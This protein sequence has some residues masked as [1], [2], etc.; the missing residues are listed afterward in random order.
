[1]GIIY[2]ASPVVAAAA[3]FTF[4]MARGDAA[5]AHIA[6]GGLL[7]DELVRPSREPGPQ[8]VSAEGQAP[9]HLSVL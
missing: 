8:H 2:P 1:M 5:Q 3:S 4:I 7:E 6:A 9:S